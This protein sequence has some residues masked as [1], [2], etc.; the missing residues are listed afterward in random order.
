MVSV[1]APLGLQPLG[2]RQAAGI[3]PDDGIAQGLA[4]VTIPGDHRLALIVDPERHRIPRPLDQPP[5][6]IQQLPRVMLD[7]AG[8]RIDL[9]M[10]E[11]AEALESAICLQPIGL[12]AGGALV[13]GDDGGHGYWRPS[14]LV[15]HRH[16]SPPPSRG[17]GKEESR[18]PS[19]FPLP[20]CGGGMG[21]GVPQAVTLD[22]FISP[23]RIPRR[24]TPR[25]RAAG[26]R[27]A[28]R[29]A[30]RAA[31]SSADSRPPVH[32]PSAAAAPAPRGRRGP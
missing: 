16:P 10:L 2:E 8:L 20:P 31:S 11:P 19:F 7:P 18:P 23:P 9:A 17:R 4:A 21:R 22:S 26:D 32:R 24:S 29:C 12:A 5:Q 27:P 3:L 28:R 14:M 30:A 13:D 25:R 15:A 6:M 1:S